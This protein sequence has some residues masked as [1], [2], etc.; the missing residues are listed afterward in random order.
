MLTLAEKRSTD[1]ILSQKGVTVVTLPEKMIT[2]V[3][4]MQNMSGRWR[5]V[6]EPLKYLER[7]WGVCV[8]KGS[9]IPIG[10]SEILLVVRRAEFGINDNL[11]RV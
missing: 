8:I 11:R 9:R 4:L 1:E 6:D 5:T 3:T 2:D 10:H 7:T